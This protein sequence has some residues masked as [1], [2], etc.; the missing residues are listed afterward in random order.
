M[1]ENHE[2]GVHAMTAS[3][4]ARPANFGPGRGKGR[5]FCGIGSK[6]ELVIQAFAKFSSPNVQHTVDRRGEKERLECKGGGQSEKEL[7][8]GS[9]SLWW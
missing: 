5:Y 9:S 1:K 6:G 3:G 7:S 4:R 8:Q 2:E